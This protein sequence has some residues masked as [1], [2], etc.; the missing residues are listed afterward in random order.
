MNQ[1]LS[2]VDSLEEPIGPLPD[3]E[4]AAYREFVETPLEVG[5][6]NYRRVTKTR[7]DITAHRLVLRRNHSSRV[8]ERLDQVSYIAVLRIYA[9]TVIIGS[10]LHLPNASVE[11]RARCIQFADDDSDSGLLDITPEALQTS[12]PDVG[13]AGANGLDAGGVLLY[14]EQIIDTNVAATRLVLRG[15]NGQAA[16]PGH[17]GVDGAHMPTLEVD[18]DIPF[19]ILKGATCS[20]EYFAQHAGSIQ[21]VVFHQE[22][23]R[24]GDLVMG[25]EKWPG[26]GEDS[27][28][29]GSPGEGGAGGV[30][31]SNASLAGRYDVSG[32]E[33]GKKADDYQAGGAPGK[34]NPAYHSIC[35]P[36]FRDAKV[37]TSKFGAGA[38]SPAASVSHGA[39]GRFELEPDSLAWV[40]VNAAEV[41][42]RYVEDAYLLRRRDDARDLLTGYARALRTWLD[43]QH[44][45]DAER[46]RPEIAVLSERAQTLMTQLASSLDYFGNP[47]GWVPFLSVE[48]YHEIFERDL[49]QSLSALYLSTWLT[50]A[51]TDAQKRTLVLQFG[52]AQLRRT[53][54][55]SVA[56][57]QELLEKEVPALE[58]NV[59]RIIN[60]HKYF[61]DAV[62]IRHQ[63][64][65]RMAQDNVDDRRRRA[66]SEKALRTFTRILSLIPIGQP[67]VAIAAIAIE[68]IATDGDYGAAAQRAAASF[69]SYSDYAKDIDAFKEAF[70]QIDFSGSDAFS[71]SFNANREKLAQ[72]GRGIAEHIRRELAEL[73]KIVV[74]VSDVEA[75]LQGLKQLDATYQDLITRVAELLVLKHEY[76]EQLVR[77]RQAMLSVLGD[78]GTQQDVL[79]GMADEYAKKITANN[80]TLARVVRTFRRR[81]EDRLR[82]YY[83]SFARAYEYRLLSAW[84]RPFDMDDIS[85]TIEE[86]AD[87]AGIEMPGDRIESIG[88]GYRDTLREVAREVVRRFEKNGGQRELARALPLTEEELAVLNRG[89]EVALDLRS[90]IDVVEDDQRI[91]S[92]AVHSA[93]ADARKGSI[94]IEVRH[95]GVSEITSRGRTF[96]FRHVGGGGGDGLYWKSVY[97]AEFDQVSNAARSSADVSLLEALIGGTGARLELF[98]RPGLD[99]VIRLRSA[100]KPRGL[101]LTSL[102][103]TVQ[104]S[105]APSQ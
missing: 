9:D 100:P 1:V 26:D 79:A 98:A 33:A 58:T 52:I 95:S 16:G 15:G 54:Q 34:P 25:S 57:Y 96:V 51:I 94:D 20:P 103:L 19:P 85:K 68:T 21:S 40:T 78:V 8:L 24:G 76:F 49:H 36:G 12:P 91:V 71:K 3:T 102:A 89:E 77:V 82:E 88:A 80:P 67:Y 53:I 64:L 2:R 104:Y 47:P 61:V 6:L 66:E 5:F 7:V 50:R 18:P 63:Q 83:Y 38:I 92:I 81:S 99:A 59:V 55:E 60:L 65:L 10:R 28:P 35:I 22:R 30:L 69:Q 45:A 101:N 90:R 70:D 41:A 27:K 23:R 105:F 17:Q 84:R 42:I 11:I 72:S 48:L 13:A 97:S 73:S 74:P 93:A 43:S 56:K 32:G 75:E 31:R 62:T 46:Q 44:D 29:G 4:S 86:V 14:A 37:R 39:E 87:S